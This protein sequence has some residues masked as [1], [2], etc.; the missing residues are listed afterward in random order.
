MRNGLLGIAMMALTLVG[1]AAGAEER[2]D[3]E[4]GQKRV[5]T[6]EGLSRVA[7]GD[8]EKAE[9]RTKGRSQIEIVGKAPGTTL[10]LTWGK[11]KED[12]KEYTVVVTE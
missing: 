4:V 2:I 7:V 12:R 6:V 8:T 10:L 11:K 1:T 9:A 5:I 3:L